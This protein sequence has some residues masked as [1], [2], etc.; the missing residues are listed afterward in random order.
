MG[1]VDRLIIVLLGEGHGVDDVAKE[2]LRRSIAGEIAI[3]EDA[4]TSNLTCAFLASV[5]ECLQ[6]LSCLGLLE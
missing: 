2:L 3:P 6:I 1:S 5:E 4:D